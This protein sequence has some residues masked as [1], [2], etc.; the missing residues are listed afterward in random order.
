M[1]V[2]DGNFLG[3]NGFV[4]VELLDILALIADKCMPV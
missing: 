2:T 4:K 1:A 3:L